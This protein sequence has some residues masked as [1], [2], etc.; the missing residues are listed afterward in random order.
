M[1]NNA[2]LPCAEALPWVICSGT[3]AK[4]RFAVCP[5]FGTRQSL[6]HTA[7]WRFPVVSSDERCWSK[8]HTSKPSLGG[9]AILTDPWTHLWESLAKYHV[10]PYSSLLDAT[11]SHAACACPLINLTQH[12][13]FMRKTSAQQHLQVGN[14][15]LQFVGI[16]QCNGPNQWQPFC[17]LLG[18]ILWRNQGWGCCWL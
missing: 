18:E 7:N 15:E 11:H 3:L 2:S 5:N 8:H 4:G 9:G 14:C 12:C 13:R 17:E 16:Y 6:L 1:A 10:V